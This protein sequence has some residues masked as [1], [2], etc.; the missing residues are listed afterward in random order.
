MKKQITNKLMM[1]LFLT[2]ICLCAS[3]IALS[4]TQDILWLGGRPVRIS[5][6][7]NNFFDSARTAN[8]SKQSNEISN[9]YSAL[10]SNDTS[11]SQQEIFYTA[12]TQFLFSFIN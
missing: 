1:T 8:I 12:L 4:Q 2:A 9:N 3:N 5:G 10:N 7:T 6:N 11:V